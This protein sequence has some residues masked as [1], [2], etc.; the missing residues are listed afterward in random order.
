M[1]E[2]A[3]NKI[4]SEMDSNKDNTYVQYIGAYLI[5]YLN[6]NP[7]DADKV[8]AEDKTI[9]KSLDEMRKV[10]EKKKT[11]NFAMLTP[12]EGFGIIM[13]YFGIDH[14]AII[15]PVATAPAQ[16]SIMTTRAEPSFDVKLEDL[17]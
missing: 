8:L 13:K 15:Q 1:L 5:Q 11:G 16:E 7:K 2:Q 3:I 10:A 12:D 17:F 6:Q 9:A 4:K 14:G